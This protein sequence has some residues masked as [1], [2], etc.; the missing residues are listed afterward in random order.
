MLS[1]KMPFLSAS[2]GCPQPEDLIADS[3]PTASREA[4]DQLGA[5]GLGKEVQER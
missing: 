1:A 3:T 5:A 2:M 4:V